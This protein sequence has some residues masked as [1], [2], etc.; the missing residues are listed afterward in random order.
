MIAP[1]RSQEQSNGG[2]TPTRSA[3]STPT[4]S[5]PSSLPADRA[6]AL[7]QQRFEARAH[8]YQTANETRPALCAADEADAIRR[9]YRSGDGRL[10]ALEALTI[11]RSLY[12]DELAGIVREQVRGPLTN[13]ERAEAKEF[14]DAH[15]GT[16]PLPAATPRPLPAAP[17][18]RP[19][20]P[21][22]PSVAQTIA[23]SSPSSAP[24]TAL[25]V[26]PSATLEIEYTSAAGFACRL[27]ITAPTGVAAID[28]GQAAEKKLK[29]LGARPPVAAPSSSARSAPSN[30][31]AE[32][33]AG[34]PPK[35]KY[36]GSPMKE[37]K[38]GG[39]WFCPRKIQGGG[40]CDFT[41]E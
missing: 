6:E 40:Y 7:A 32:S 24:S 11:T 8:D 21:S 41:V 34:D 27:V 22:T 39:K 36:H 16:Q 23:P 15:G 9:S 25:A 12:L 13:F 33:G 26:P 14:F 3:P 5:A 30:P 28:A 2:S 4:R 38:G 10:K 37:G 1:R 31:D 29:G 18:S 35:C 19:N 20:A 17:S